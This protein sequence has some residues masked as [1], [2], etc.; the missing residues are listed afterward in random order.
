MHRM[1]ATVGERVIDYLSSLGQEIASSP[2]SR[3]PAPPLPMLPATGQELDGLLDHIF[4]HVLPPGV[5][6]AGPGYLGYVPGGGLFQAALADFITKCTNRHAGHESMAPGLIRLEWNVVRWLCDVMG[7]P[8]TA[9]GALTTGGSLSNLMAIVAARVDRL[10]PNFVSGVVY[11]SDQCHHSTRR[12]ARTAGF[13]AAQ[14]RRLPTDA[15]F[16]ISLPHLAQAIRVDRAAGLQPFLVVGSA[17]TTNTGAIDD[18]AALADLAGD[19]AL[20]LHVDAAYGGFFALTSEGRRELAGLSRADSIT[21]DPHKGLGLPYGTG[22][23]VV[24]DRSTLRR[25]FADQEEIDYL[26]ALEDDEVNFCDMTPELSREVRGLRLWLPMQLC[27][28]DAFA[29]NLEEKLSLAREA[30]QLLR[31]V[32]GIE[33]ADDPQLS[34]VAFRLV[35]RTRGPADQDADTRE[36]LRRVNHRGSVFLSSTT[37]LGQVWIRMCVLSFRTHQEHVAAAISDIRAEAADILALGSVDQRGGA[38]VSLSDLFVEVAT[39]RPNAPA[40]HSSKGTITYRALLE[41]ATRIALILRERGVTTDV[42]VGVA[43]PRSEDAVAAVLGI[44]L[45]GGAYVPIDPSY[46]VE[47]QRLILDDSGAA[48]V[49]CPTA[50]AAGWIAASRRLDLD[51]LPE[52]PN[53]APPLPR[54]TKDRLLYIL[55]TSGSTGRPKGVC[56]THDATFRRL[57]WGW[58]TRPFEADEVGSHRTS[59]NFVDSVVE[60]FSGLLRG[61]PTAILDSED[62]ADLGRL[63]G[64][65]RRYGVTRL[66]VVPS[67]LAAMLRVAPDLAGALPRLRLCASSGEELS[68]ELCARFRA[69]HP[70]ATLLNLYGST[71]ITGDVSC[72]EFLPDT[73]VPHDRVPI[74]RAIAGSELLLFDEDLVEVRDGETGELYVGGPLVAR[75]YHARPDEQARRFVPHP[76]R[77]GERLFRT[78]DLMRR[79]A[80]GQLEYLGRRDNQVKIRGVRVELEEVERA[81]SAVLPPEGCV[82]VVV[83]ETGEPLSSGRLCAVASPADVDLSALRRSA[84]ASLAPAAVPSRFLAIDALPRTPNGKI[85]RV[86]LARWAAEPHGRGG[87]APIETEGE[88]SLGALWS[89]CLD[90][91]PVGRDD[92]FIGLGGD[93]LAFAELVAALS[94][95]QGDGVAV[96]FAL[97]RDG[98]LAEIA[99]W[100]EQRPDRVAAPATPRYEAVDAGL[101]DPGHLASVIAEAFAAREPL[102]VATAVT[103]AE[104]RGYA[105]PVVAACATSGLSFVARD[106]ATGAVA[107]FC[108]AVDLRRAPVIP[109]TSVA[110][111]LWPTLALLGGLGEAYLRHCAAPAAG[112]VVELVVTGVVAGHDGYEVASM[113]EDRTLAAG[114]ALGYQHAMTICTHR[115]TALLAQRAGFRRVVAESYATTE[116]ANRRVFASIGPE[117]RE[118]AVYEKAL[119]VTARSQSQMA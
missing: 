49:L 110:P 83:T 20:W 57:Q 91:V 77:A 18:L 55:Y 119:Q 36:L 61:V 28:T 107:G 33:L 8:A 69:A 13:P 109:P 29:A 111:S 45:A 17:G 26:P 68:P 1:L 41:R 100:L 21:L 58:A 118:A 102:T 34:T 44:L 25:A 73:P 98:T 80:D 117:H 94:P 84:A 43:L 22:A 85:D 56:G 87:G 62:L 76:T 105:V 38:A 75:G 108:M 19:E 99:R 27:G 48:L 64:T 71:E 66:T 88:R 67:I 112:D 31:Q 6:T 47:R 70:R 35:G 63:L 10:P 39:A 115:V 60:L 42:T 7:L 86:A 116:F 103:A 81:I 97:L 78:G 95:S 93:S 5:N 104:F 53:D 114:R 2:E 72:A 82:A 15:R 37:L 3:S 23:L 24:R 79:R 106:S 14:V 16:R 90:G 92:T 32:P 52:V 65:L 12:A 40:L 101:V 4:D 30:A 11:T 89:T 113:L 51:T 9:G 50:S 74:G 54:F 96:P 46:P 59:L